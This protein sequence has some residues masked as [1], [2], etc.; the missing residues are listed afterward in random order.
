ML[1]FVGKGYT[2]A[3]VT[4]FEQVVS[5]IAAGNEPIEIVA[6]PDDICAALLTE[7]DCHCHNPDIV[8]RD[9]HAAKA[10]GDL[11][12]QP[13]QPGAHILLGDTQLRLLRQSFAA[14][15]IRQACV[16][17]QWKATCDAVAKDQFK[18][19]QFKEA[20]LARGLL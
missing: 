10:I 1:T 16:G 17:C 14:G 20:A 18:E 15:T 8:L 3:F 19:A 6:G 11:L 13:V 7:T 2:S 12:Q 5:R 4:N 9:H